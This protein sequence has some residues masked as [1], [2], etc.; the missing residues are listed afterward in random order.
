MT[1]RA[2]GTGMTIEDVVAVARSGEKVELTTEAQERIRHC[3]SMLERKVDAH[4]IMYGVNTGIGELAEVVLTDDQVKDFQKYLIYNHAAGIGD[5][6]PVEHVRA[7]MLSRINV[8]CKGHSGGRPVITETYVKM[9]NAGITPVVC[10][11]G[12]VG[13]CGDLAPMSQNRSL[14]HGRGRVLPRRTEDADRQGHG[15]VRH[16]GP[17]S[18]GTRRPGVHQRIEPDHRDVVPHPP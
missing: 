15:E 2:N 18:E 8:H 3:R 7:A 6:C 16:P 14:P 9:L 1:V 10:E 12:S 13:A 4:E 17:G 5:P 11:K